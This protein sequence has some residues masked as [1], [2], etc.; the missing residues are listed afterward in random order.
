MTAAAAAAALFLHLLTVPSKMV[1]LACSSAAERR[2]LK[3]A[4][5]SSLFGHTSRHI[6][7]FL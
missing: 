6:F 1:C 2:Y 4:F 3:E 7:L 5:W